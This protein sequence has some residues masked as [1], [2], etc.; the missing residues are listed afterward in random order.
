MTKKGTI[1]HLGGSWERSYLRL[2]QRRRRQGRVGQSNLAAG[3][4]RRYRPPSVLRS[5][6]SLTWSSLSVLSFAVLR[7]SHF[8]S[9]AW[10]VML[11]PD[12]VHLPCPP[13]FIDV[14][15]VKSFCS[16]LTL[17][18]DLIH[19]GFEK[20]VGHAIVGLCDGSDRKPWKG[21]RKR[22]KLV[23]LSN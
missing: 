19:E 6:R 8:T 3:N 12:A 2:R 5:S 13:P 7:H 18:L 22:V 11:S 15:L 1:S 10:I 21:T 23:L 14:T 16:W 20:N 4:G 17:R 9:Y